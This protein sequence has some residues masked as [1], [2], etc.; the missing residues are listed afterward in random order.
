MSSVRTATSAPAAFSLPTSISFCGVMPT[1]Y[2]MSRIPWRG[3][4]LRLGQ[5]GDRDAAGLAAQGEAGDIHGFCGLH[6]RAQS[7]PMPG[8]GAR[9][10]VEVPLQDAAIEHQAGG[11]QIL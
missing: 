9:H 3:E 7:Q 1:A 2:R 11:R 4:I 5:G 8:D 10:G 6:V